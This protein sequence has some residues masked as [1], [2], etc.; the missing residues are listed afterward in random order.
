MTG[1]QRRP[2]RRRVVLADRRGAR[3]VHTRVEVAEHTEIGAA[4]IGGLIRAQLGLAL[5]MGLIAVAVLGVLPA[6]FTIDAVAS[7]AVLGIRLPWLLLGVMASPL[8]FAVGRLFI[9]LA[10]RNENDFL[11]LTED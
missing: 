11:D 1:P 2:V 6:L 9:R 8:L 10:E 7:A 5:R 4:L 3:R